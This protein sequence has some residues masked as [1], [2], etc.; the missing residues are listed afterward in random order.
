MKESDFS[1]TP[2]TYHFFNLGCPKNLV[3][4]ERTAARLEEKGWR[5]T[6]DPAS[7]DLLVITTCA[8][9]SIAEEESVNEILRVSSGRREDQILAVLGCL[10]TREGEKLVGLIP[11]VDIFLPVKE[12]ESLADIVTDRSCPV[13]PS[14]SPP[15]RLLIGKAGRRLFTPSHIAYLK[16]SEGCSN[17]CA[18]CKIPSIRGE[19]ESRSR[20]DILFEIEALSAAG[21][22]ELVIIAQDTTAYGHETG[23]KQSLYH[24]L[25]D[26]ADRGSFDWIRLM[27][28][29]PAHT[30]AKEICRLSESGII[31]PYLDIPIQHVSDGVLRRMKRGY[32]RRELED[33]IGTLRSIDPGMVLRTTVMTGF[34]GETDEDFQE[35]TDFLEKYR[36]DHVGVFS[37]SAENGTPAASLGSTISE[38]TARSRADEVISIQMDISY[39]RLAERDG[40]RL[41]VLVDDLVAPDHAPVSGVWGTGRFYGQS[42]EIDGVIYLSG[43]KTEPGSFSLADVTEVEAY[44]LFATVR[45][46]LD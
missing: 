13:I 25:E 12:M 24:L 26:I 8:F 19:L 11:E 17:H 35:L 31:I 6:G 20:G 40:K 30:D 15:D 42:Y 32:G 36:F 46:D 34:P 22:K 37:Y 44:D 16:I 38:D 4:A 1:I 10:V 3:D 29:H 18:Y 45:E 43:R 33:I 9:I 2:G 39:E 28:M 21:I 7:A 41:K 14:I 5:E 23:E 27:Y